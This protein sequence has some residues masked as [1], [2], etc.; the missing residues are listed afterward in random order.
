MAQR[1]HY[2]LYTALYYSLYTIHYTL[3]YTKHY[4]TRTALNHRLHSTKLKASNQKGLIEMSGGGTA[5]AQPYAALHY[6]AQKIGVQ[7][8]AVQCNHSSAIT[9]QYTVQCNWQHFFTAERFALRSRGRLRHP[10][11]GS[12]LLLQYKRIHPGLSYCLSFI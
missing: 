2:T 10:R 9:V 12:L 4:E 11:L 5:G 6:T 3:Y 1:A 7:Y 8:T